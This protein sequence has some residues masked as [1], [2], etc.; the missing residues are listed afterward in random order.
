MIVRWL[1]V[2]ML[3]WGIGFTIDRAAAQGIGDLLT[4]IARGA[5]GLPIPSTG[6]PQAQS[7]GKSGKGGGTSGEAVYVCSKPVGAGNA[8][9]AQKEGILPGLGGGWGGVAERKDQEAKHCYNAAL[10]SGL[11]GCKDIGYGCSECRA[12]ASGGKSVY[13]VRGSGGALGR[14]P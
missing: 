4:G 2:A 9:F 13:V 7:P 8:Q 5:T 3:A 14:C 6:G 10:T 1:A 11:S 12:T